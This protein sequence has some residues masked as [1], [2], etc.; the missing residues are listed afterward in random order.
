M[1]ELKYQLF[2]LKWFFTNKTENF[3]HKFWWKI[4]KCI[5]RWAVLNAWARATTEC[6]TN[7]YP[8]EVDVWMCLNFLEGK[9]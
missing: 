6:Y 8:D 5:L 1:S 7:K 9:K 2:R 3:L 4:P